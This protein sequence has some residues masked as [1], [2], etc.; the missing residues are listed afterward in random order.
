MTTFVLAQRKKPLRPCSEK[1]LEGGWNGVSPGHRIVPFPI[2]RGDRLQEDSVVKSL[3][4]KLDPG[5]KTTGAVLVREWET[6]DS[7]TGA[8]SRS[9][10]GRHSPSAG[11]IIV[12]FSDQGLGT[13]WSRLRRCR[14]NSCV[15]IGRSSR[16]LK[17]GGPSI[18]RGH[19]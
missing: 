5:R 15:S 12:V 4:L 16:I 17:V 1:R 6:V 9:A 2:R 11:E 10:A 7:T 14:R 3:R 18:S 13:I 19:S 8:V